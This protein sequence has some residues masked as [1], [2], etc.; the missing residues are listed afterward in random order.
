MLRLENKYPFYFFLFSLFFLIN[1]CT[2]SPQT[3]TL[4]GVVQLDGQVDHSAI[5]VALYEL[6]SLDP[7]IVAIN[8][9]YPHI[10]VIIN[11]MTEFDHRFGNI[12]KYTQTDA[13]G[14]FKIKDIPTGRYNF[15]AMKDSFGFRYIYEV[16]ITEGDNNLEEQRKKEKGKSKKVNIEEND[17][18]NLSPLIFNLNKSEAGIILYPETH[19][20]THIDTATIWQADHHYIIENDIFVSGDLTIKPGA[21][22]R[23][24]KDK[25][26]TI[27]GDLTAVGEEENMIWFTSNDSLS[28]LPFTFYFLPL[29]PKEEFI[30]YTFN[31]VELTGTEAK[32]VA[33]CKFDHAG[34]GLLNHVN[35]FSI[36]DCIFRNSNC[37][38]KS[39]N[40]DSTFC[41]NLL[42]E[43]ISG[44]S[45]GGLYFNDVIDG[46]INNNVIINSQTGIKLKYHCSDEI[47][48]N[49]YITD[50]YNGMIITFYSSP[51]ILNNNICDCEYD[52]L[53]AAQSE[54]YI[55]HNIISGNWTFHL[56]YEPGS[57]VFD[58]CPIIKN[59]NL[60]AIEYFYYIS[61]HN[62][63]DI[64]THYNYYGIDVSEI[65]SMIYD[66]DD[67]PVEYQ[68]LVGNVI[69]SPS[70]NANGNCGIQ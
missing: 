13:Y 57:N 5:I 27:S 10:G 52:I 19:I 59:N 44:E 25:K 11:Q 60:E 4:S 37:G 3:G 35:G 38:F 1:Y 67:Y 68:D 22:I 62:K 70:G 18:F 63:K 58:A 51:T 28:F 39:E 21:V 53:I 15:M 9:E 7:D 48:Y 69:Y 41:S 30:P 55:H 42:C 50:C 34:T 14:N 43:N 64:I 66:K 40:V 54:P 17:S 20:S 26:L 24:E 56:Y 8:Q 65:E 47:I 6:A 29:P 33:W 16:T 32:Q 46:L 61:K 49:N 36:S 23:I 12:V 2:T 31:R 45:E